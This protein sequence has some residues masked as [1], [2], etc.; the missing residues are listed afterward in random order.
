M[1][2]TEEKA[3]R[4]RERVSRSVAYSDSPHVTVL[5]SAGVPETEGEAERERKR[6]SGVQR[7]TAYV[8]FTVDAR[9][10]HGR[11]RLVVTLLVAGVVAPRSAH[12][13]L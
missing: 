11:D 2:E 6:V 8:A 12:G 13:Q 10:A 7:L 9:P 4:E 5:L 3:E 1:P